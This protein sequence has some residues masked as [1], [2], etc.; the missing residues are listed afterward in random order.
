MT[1]TTI[2]PEVTTTEPVIITS[3]VNGLTKHDR[4]DYCR[5]QAYSRV[6]LRGS[7][8]DL[9]FCKHHLEDHLSAITPQAS[10]IE[11]YRDSINKKP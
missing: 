9:L 3:E 6:V 2:A 8:F 1:T 7:G 10:R 4:C 5:V 11:D